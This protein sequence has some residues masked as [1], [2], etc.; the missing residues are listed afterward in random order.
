MKTKIKKLTDEQ[1]E[2]L[3]NIPLNEVCQSLGYE[4][5]KESKEFYR[6]K[7]ENLNLVLNTEKNSFAE[8]KIQITDLEQ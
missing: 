5:K 8:N 6:V 2:N 1:M 4:V 7:T 3:R